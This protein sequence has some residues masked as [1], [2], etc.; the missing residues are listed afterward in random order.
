MHHLGYKRHRQRT[1]VSHGHIWLGRILIT[2]GMINGGLGLLLSNNASRGECIAYGVIAGL[3]WL[4]W[5]ILAAFGERR[6][7]QARGPVPVAASKPANGVGN[8]PSIR[9][10]GVDEKAG[11]NY[12]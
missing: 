10:A 6:R 4:L 5:V 3:V 7:S 11:P 2:L 1:I 8:E 12:A 9:V